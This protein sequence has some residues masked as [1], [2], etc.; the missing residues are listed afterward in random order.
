MFE[1]NLGTLV[2]LLRKQTKTVDK[3]QTSPPQLVTRKILETYPACQL[4]ECST[5]E[6]NTAPTIKPSILWVG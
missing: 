3:H 4:S 5:T 6:G 1:I 2:S